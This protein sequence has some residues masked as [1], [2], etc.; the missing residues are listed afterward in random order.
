MAA[1]A[2]AAAL[3]TLIK[4]GPVVAVSMEQAAAAVA[5]F[6]LAAELAVL[7]VPIRRAAVELLAA[8]PVILTHSRRGMAAAAR[9]IFHQLQAVPVALLVAA[10]AAAHITQLAVLAGG[11]SAEFGAVEIC[12]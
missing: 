2:A 6:P 1:A 12:R 5:L 3:I 9:W 8:V 7:G 4:P 10:A 11:P